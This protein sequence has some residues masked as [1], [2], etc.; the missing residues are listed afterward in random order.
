MITAAT[1]STRDSRFYVFG[2]AG[3]VLGLGLMVMAVVQARNQ[4]SPPSPWGSS[5]LLFAGQVVASA[6]G[7]V[8]V[9]P[10]MRRRQRAA[11]VSAGL[12]PACGYDLRATPGRCPECGRTGTGR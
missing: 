8:V 2:V 3:I 11:R 7:Y 9:V 6:G 4:P 12:C 5:F 1:T 10:L